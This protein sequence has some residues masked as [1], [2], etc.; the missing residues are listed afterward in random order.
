VRQ[1]FASLTLSSVSEFLPEFEPRVRKALQ[2]LLGESA[3]RVRMGLAKDGS[4]VGG[5]SRVDS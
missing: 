1:I 3:N 5:M 2:A 4:G